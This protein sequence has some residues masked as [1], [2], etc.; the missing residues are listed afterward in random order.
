MTAFPLDR[1]IFTPDDVDLNRSPLRRTLQAD[2]YVLGAFNPGLTRLPGGNLLMMVRIAEALSE[3]VVEDRVRAIRWTPEGYRLESW[4]MA[5]V[6]MTDP[7]QFAFKQAGA[8]LQGLTSISWLLPVELTP[9]GSQVVAVHYDRAIEPSASYQE[10]GVEDA[11]ISLIDGRYWMTLCSVSP[12][13]LGTSLYTSDDGLDWTLQGLVLDHLNKDMMLF[14]GKPDGRFLALTRPLGDGYFAYAEDSPYRGGP[15]INMATSPDGL[16]W[17]PL[18]TGGVR[19][20]KACAGS[21]KIGGGTP[22]LLTQEGWLTLYHG[23][24]IKGAVGIYRTFWVLFDRDDPTRIVR[25]EDGAPLIESDPA[26]IAPI[27]HQQYL[28][29]P[30]VFTTGL[31]D[32]GDVFIAAS[33]EA[34]LACR[35]TH[36]P[37]A[38]FV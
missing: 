28:P 32:G 36:I 23:V 6:D 12:E 20:R 8:R 31:V 30:V 38:R 11:R 19:A 15:S 34:D 4:P 7:R 1:L 37:K 24:E 22:P 21:S 27:A 2:T 3:P 35:I 17:K 33:G 29:T 10:Y 5:Q 16:H 14:E 18:E 9:D 13:R 26:L 25:L